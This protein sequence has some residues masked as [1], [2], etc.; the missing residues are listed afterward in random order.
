VLVTQAYAYGVAL[1]QI[2]LRIDPA[3][4]EVVAKSAASFQPGPIRPPGCP[5]IRPRAA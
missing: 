4:R 2:D 1:A 3:T 5:A